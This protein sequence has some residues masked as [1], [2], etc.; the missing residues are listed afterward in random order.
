MVRRNVSSAPPPSV[1][2][3]LPSVILHIR[4]V[5][6]S[7]TVFSRKDPIRCGRRCHHRRGGPPRKILLRSSNRKARTTVLPARRGRRDSCLARRVNRISSAA[8][9][10]DFFISQF[11]ISQRWWKLIC[12]CWRA[13]WEALVRLPVAKV[14]KIWTG[15]SVQLR[16]VQLACF[17]TFVLDPDTEEFG[18][19][20]TLFHKFQCQNPLW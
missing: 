2:L 3:G 4:I 18:H 6:E 1:L 7:C 11:R 10:V 20:L 8:T 12:W 9:K 14:D 15:S 17:I 5:H 13:E 16:Q 19:T